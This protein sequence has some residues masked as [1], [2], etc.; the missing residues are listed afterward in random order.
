MKKQCRLIVRMKA[1]DV[2][3]QIACFI[4]MISSITANTNIFGL[5]VGIMALEQ[6]LS[7][8]YWLAFPAKA[9]PR[10]ASGI[11]IRSAF[12]I[13]IAGLMLC[14]VLKPDFTLNVLFAM[15]VIG[16]VLG[17]SY[18]IISVAEVSFYTRLSQIPKEEQTFLEA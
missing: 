16:P 18:F 14:F 11:F 7:T 3:L 15:I 6:C 2:Y 9:I 12:C 13:V 8:L 5:S 1:V 4:F 17:L 10:M